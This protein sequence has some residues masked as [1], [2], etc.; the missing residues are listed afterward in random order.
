MVLEKPLS[1]TYFIFF[2]VHLLYFESKGLIK[3]FSKGSIWNHGW[4]RQMK[5]NFHI[6]TSV[7]REHTMPP[8]LTLADAPAMDVR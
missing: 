8:L 7:S 4:Q 6:I 2:K 3:Y 5:V 1:L